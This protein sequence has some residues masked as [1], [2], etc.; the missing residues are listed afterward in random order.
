[1][2]QRVRR[3][4]QALVAAAALTLAGGA[5]ALLL[6]AGQQAVF[7]ANLTGLDPAAP[8]DGV[9][10]FPNLA[11]PLGSASAEITVFGSPDAVDGV[12]GFAITDFGT[13]IVS[14]DTPDALNPERV[15]DGVFSLVV[16]AISGSIDIDL[17]VQGL[18]E[19]GPGEFIGTEPMRLTGR[20]IGDDGVVDPPAAVPAPA[21]L[22]LAV[23]ALAALG[24]QQR[25]RR[26]GGP[27]PL[28]A[29]A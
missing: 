10:L 5:Q 8:F 3:A 12:I 28:A 21:S 1:M 20:L 11:N 4:A 17:F 6:T 27:G 13:P 16:Q 15:L 14:A 24:R 29:V 7:N 19:V 26:P 18:Q 25:T 2:R 23:L 9:R 22:A